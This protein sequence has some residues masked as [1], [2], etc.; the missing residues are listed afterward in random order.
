MEGARGTIARMKKFLEVLGQA[1]LSPNPPVS[2]GP[3]GP[4][5][6]YHSHFQHSLLATSPMCSETTHGGGA[7]KG[8]SYATKGATA[9]DWLGE[10][11][12]PGEAGGRQNLHRA[13]KIYSWKGFYFAF[14]GQTQP[15]P[16]G[17]GILALPQAIT[18]H[19]MP[20]LNPLVL[21]LLDWKFNTLSVKQKNC[22]Y[23][24]LSKYYDFSF[25]SPQN[26]HFHFPSPLSSPS[27]HNTHFGERPFI[28]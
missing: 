15:L 24:V 1:P 3:V 5:A 25:P 22:F 14:T 17:Y 8:C 16:W 11:G 28:F 9:E 4:T 12:G 10:E 21:S 2:P 13:H 19:T 20:L 6:T 7:C 23:A 18:T 26:T 27:P